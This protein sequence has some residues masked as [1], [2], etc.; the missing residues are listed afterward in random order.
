MFQAVS[1][2]LCRQMVANLEELADMRAGQDMADVSTSQLVD[3]LSSRGVLRILGEP[4]EKV[5]RLFDKVALE[6]DRR[7]PPRRDYGGDT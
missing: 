3:L 6:L 7:L 5:E 2:A 4:S 1:V